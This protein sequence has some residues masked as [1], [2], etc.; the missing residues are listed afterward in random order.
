MKMQLEL[1]NVTKTK[2]MIRYCESL[3]YGGQI[4]LNNITIDLTHVSVPAKKDHNS[5]QPSHMPLRDQHSL[6]HSCP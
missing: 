3:R 2:E 5:H 4:T 6:A 1:T